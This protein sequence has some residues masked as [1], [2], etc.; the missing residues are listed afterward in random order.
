MSHNSQKEY[1][2]KIEQLRSILVNSLSSENLP[3]S[4]SD[5]CMIYNKISGI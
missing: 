2:K 4:S 3:C 1:M 5:N